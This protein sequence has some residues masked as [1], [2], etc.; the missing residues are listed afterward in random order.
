MCFFGGSD[1]TSPGTSGTW[2][3]RTIGPDKVNQLRHA[4]FLQRCDGV[5]ELMAR[6][7]AILAPKFELVAS[8]LQERLGALRVATW[9]EPKGG[10]FVSLDVVDGTASRV[11]ELARRPGSR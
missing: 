8:I 9:T 10:Y 3:K 5:H 4:R 2:R 7:R 6:H 11:V 1:A